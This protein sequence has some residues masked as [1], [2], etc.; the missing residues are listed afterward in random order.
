MLSE[1]ENYRQR[2]DHLRGQVRE[3]IAGLPP[4]ALNWR[5]IPL[6]GQEDPTNSLAV[7]AAHVVGAEHF[8]I[9]EVVGGRPPTRD[10]DAEFATHTTHNQ[11]LVALIDKTAAETD[12]VLASLAPSALDGDRQAADRK[13]SVRWSLLH[14]AAHTA[15]HLGHMQLTYQ[16][17][18]GGK[19]KPT[20]FWHEILKEGESE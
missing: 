14:V 17:W 6:G 2:I 16:L 20:P 18:M 11:E 9:A 12:E 7:L 10:R 8:W 19:S 5:P 3:L 13:V 15:L 4:E 1:L